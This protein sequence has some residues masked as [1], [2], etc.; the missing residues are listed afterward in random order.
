MDLWE[1]HQY[2]FSP[3]VQSTSVPTG[4]LF[5]RSRTSSTSSINSLVDRPATMSPTLTTP[6]G[7]CSSATQPLNTNLELGLGHLNNLVSDGQ[8]TTGGSQETP[9]VRV[10]T[11]RVRDH[12]STT[13]QSSTTAS[14]I[15][16]FSSVSI[17]HTKRKKSLQRANIVSELESAEEPL[18]SAVN[19]PAQF[20]QRPWKRAGNATTMARIHYYPRLA[21][22]QII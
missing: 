6:A 20:E 7:D 11:G 3:P 17:S 12:A 1:L 10:S 14:A 13:T 18:S 4:G 2:Y 8:S 5:A 16:H 9:R 19:G 21:V 22:S 15:T